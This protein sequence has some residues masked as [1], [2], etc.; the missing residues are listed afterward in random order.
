MLKVNQLSDKKEWYGGPITYAENQ[1]N[2]KS[3]LSFNKFV[4]MFKGYSF[5]HK[6]GTPR[7][8]W[9]AMMSKSFKGASTFIVL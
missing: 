3:S 5:D 8:I 7:D 6:L 9:T 4:P 1:T 2:K